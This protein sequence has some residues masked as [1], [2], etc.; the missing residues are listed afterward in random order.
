M[1]KT[2]KNLFENICSFE[3]LYNAYLKARRGHRKSNSV[4]HFEQN[5][6]G[7]LF[8]L[9]DE[10]ATGTYKTGKYNHFK[11][12]EPKERIISSLPF[13]DRILQHA[14]V[15]AIEFIWEKNFIHTSYACRTA[16]GSHAGADQAQKYLREV[17]REFGEI[18]VLKADISKYFS[19]IDHNILKVLIRKRIYDVRILNIIDEI[20]DSTGCTV[21]IPIGNL[22]SQLFA[23]IYLHELD[24][25]VKH[26][27][28][29]PR[30][31][32]YMDDFVVFHKNKHHL[33][34]MRATVE[35]FLSKHLRLL[36]NSKTQV[37]KVSQNRGR[38]LDFL[39]YRMWVTHRRL[40]KSSVNRMRH[41]IKSISKQYNLGKIEREEITNKISSWLGH[42]KHA[43]SYRIRNILLEG[44]TF[45]R[46]IEST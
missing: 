33:T 6:E 7:N 19:N 14:L 38:A 46:I 4:L 8:D 37:Y 42:A 27:L 1:A 44:T 2:Y 10:L 16:K 28:R 23:N 29:E 17:K 34:L 25:F 35:G 24:L 45:P 41:K 15:S 22:T 32:R 18:Y 40:R 12:Y 11:I 30:Y 36:T 20:I 3:H 26:N 39:G 9:L 13:R 43:D 5:L 21:G 31:I